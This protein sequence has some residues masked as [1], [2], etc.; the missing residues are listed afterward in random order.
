MSGC[1]LHQ[2][3]WSCPEEGLHCKKFCFLR[4]LPSPGPGT[5]ICRQ[6][7]G[8]LG[9]ERSQ[10]VAEG[11]CGALEGDKL[12][13]DCTHL[14]DVLLSL[15]QSPGTC[16]APQALGT[17]EEEA[18]YAL[19]V[20]E[21][22]R[23]ERGEGQGQTDRQLKFSVPRV[24]RGARRASHS[25][26][27]APGPACRGRSWVWGR[28]AGEG[29]PREASVHTRMQEA[30]ES[31]LE[32]DVGVPSSPHSQQHHTCPIGNWKIPQALGGVQVAPRY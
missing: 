32:A 18:S 16:P 5:C 8:A 15:K 19:I 9:L 25:P 14:P 24:Q 17:N 2:V 20:L 6:S 7:G 10:A 11:A 12:A 21:V 22:W 30:E 4:G 27:R 28:M 29:Q 31:V 1:T 13:K 26:R 3:G 23:L